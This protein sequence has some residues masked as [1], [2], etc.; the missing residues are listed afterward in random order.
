MEKYCPICGKAYKPKRKDQPTCGDQDCRY[1]W[2][3]EYSRRYMAKR[4]AE[5]R[6][7]RNAYH[8]EKMREY[9]KEH[10]YGY[11]QKKLQ[12]YQ[13]RE[14]TIISTGYAERQMQQTLAM[15]GRVKI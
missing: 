10:G 1:V 14:D 13:P 9:R 12:K 15:V 5:H 4:R 2:K 7:E 8:R 3:V 11:G 6:D